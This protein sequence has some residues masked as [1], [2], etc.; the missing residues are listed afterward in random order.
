LPF[1]IGFRYTTYT[2]FTGA[3]GLFRFP[4]ALTKVQAFFVSRYRRETWFSRGIYA[5]FIRHAGFN[6]SAFTGTPE[7]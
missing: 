3:F 5:F 1:A 6:E 4:P 2:V 7:Q